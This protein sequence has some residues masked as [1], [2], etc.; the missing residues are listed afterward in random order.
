[1]GAILAERPDLH[2]GRAKSFTAKEW[3]MKSKTKP[4]PAK[5]GTKS[6]NWTRYRN[7][8][9]AMNRVLNGDVV[10]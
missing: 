10:R 1:M 3:T 7:K 5:E 4:Q 9:T 2:R 8:I 6:G